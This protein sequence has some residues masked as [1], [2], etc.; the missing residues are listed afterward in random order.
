M[1]AEAKARPGEAEIV[2]DIWKASFSVITG[3]YQEWLSDFFIW[4]TTTGGK[5]V[6]KIKKAPLLR[7]FY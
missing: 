4:S 3:I 6:F 5:N 2:N 1:N 7:G